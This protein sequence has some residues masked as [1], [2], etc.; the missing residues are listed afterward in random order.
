MTAR[1]MFNN[2]GYE[3]DESCDGILYAKYD[4]TIVGE[5]LTCVLTQIDFEKDNNGKIR[6]IKK[7]VSI[8]VFGKN[9]PA[10]ITKQ[11]LDAINKQVEE[12]QWNK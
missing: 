4:D 11:E 3:C 6:Q 8:G 12:L 9:Q 7:Q 5:E 2:L 10:Y 1:E